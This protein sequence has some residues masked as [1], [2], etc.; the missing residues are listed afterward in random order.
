MTPLVSSYGKGK[1]DIRVSWP[2]PAANVTK[3]I[4]KRNDQYLI[5]PGHGQYRISIL[6]RPLLCA[7]V[8]VNAGEGDHG[9]AF[10]GK[11]RV[12]TEGKVRGENKH[13]IHRGR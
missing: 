1:E 10:A 8:C 12:E 7:R 2:L 13:R 5:S 6:C 9:R 4:A 11:N 3:G